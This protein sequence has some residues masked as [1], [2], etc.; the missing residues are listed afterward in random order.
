MKDEVGISKM[1]GAFE[2]LFGSCEFFFNV[3]TSTWWRFLSEDIKSHVPYGLTKFAIHPRIADA[4]GQTGDGL[5]FRK[6]PTGTAQPTK[7]QREVFRSFSLISIHLD[8]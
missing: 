7:L 5:G 2:A 1:F 8:S 3:S 6:S 4:Q